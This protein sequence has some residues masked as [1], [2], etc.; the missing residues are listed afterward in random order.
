MAKKSKQNLQDELAKITDASG[1]RADAMATMRRQI[2]T[3]GKV[4]AGTLVVVWLLAFGF[5]SG[6]ESIVPVYVAAVVTVV[7]AIAA[8]MIR[9]NLGK[10]EELGALMGDGELS[11]EER[12]KRI[13]KLEGRIA[14]G[15]HAA[16]LT[17][18]Q[19]QMQEDQNGRTALETL[20]TVDL[21]KA[22]KV[23]ANQVRGMRAMIHLNHGEVKAARQLADA[24]LFDKTPDL[25]SRANLAGIVAEAWAR[26]GNPI[27]AEEL[28][29]KYDIDDPKFKDTRVQLLKAKVFVTVHRNNL[30]SMRKNLKLLE[31]VSPQLLAVFVQGKRIH[32]LLKKEATKRLQKSGIMPQPRVQ[33][34]RR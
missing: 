32:P 3:M 15:E 4:A 14:K 24:V 11:A 13:D 2:A 28:L 5:W 34:A 16:I 10:S 26:S 27:E 19:L 29:A 9:R 7:I 20:E 1:A 6:L 18:A 31:A 21:E 23:I 22:P 30:Q 17:K 33:A 12:Q 25:A 8:F